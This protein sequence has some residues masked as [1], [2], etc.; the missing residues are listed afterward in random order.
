M[1][2]MTTE[3][4]TFQVGDRVIVPVG[5][6][7]SGGTGGVYFGEGYQRHTVPIE[8]EVI[9]VDPFG[10]GSARGY[11][12]LNVKGTNQ[13]G[14]ELTQYVDAMCVTR[15]PSKTADDG[16]KDRPLKVGDRVRIVT[17]N[18]LPEFAG[19]ECEVVRSNG[20][21]HG[22]GE[23]YLK[24]LTD[25][26]DIGG[27]YNFYWPEHDL[28]LVQDDAPS[29]E[30]QDDAPAVKVG[31]RVRVLHALH[32]EPMVG[33]TGVVTDASESRG[34][35]LS[36][37]PHPY[38]V[39][40][41]TT[42]DEREDSVYASKVEVLPADDDDPTLVKLAAEDDAVQRADAA[43]KALSEFRDRVRNVLMAATDNYGLDDVTVD[44]LLADLDLDPR[45]LPDGFPTGRYS[46]VLC[47]EGR[48]GIRERDDDRPWTLYYSSGVPV[49]IKRT[50][51]E[52]AREYVITLYAGVAA[53]A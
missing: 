42:P 1:S 29:A 6:T 39:K 27:R 33:R 37:V 12:T 15:A 32:A 24:P 4:P 2:A 18:S 8:V 25:R 40:I 38:R 52:V 14:E 21:S 41:D 20:W 26:P 50:D 10:D 7:S 35:V 17:G 22:P 31:D 30:S 46:V 49:L 11:L 44:D 13:D 45:P 3:S 48:I 36:G 47:K 16:S 51:Q 5:A 9:E 43:M 28:T 34:L 23:V 53:A 19:L